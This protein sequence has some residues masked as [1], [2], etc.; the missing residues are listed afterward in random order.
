[1]YRADTPKTCLTTQELVR[2]R[3]YRVGNIHTP[4][5]EMRV[6]VQYRDWSAIDLI[7]SSKGWKSDTVIAA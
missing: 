3:K 4:G 2:N 6:K 5:I 7:K 1:M